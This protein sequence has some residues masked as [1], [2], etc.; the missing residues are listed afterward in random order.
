MTAIS[1]HLNYLSSFN[2]LYLYTNKYNPNLHELYVKSI[3]EKNKKKMFEKH[4]Y[5][6][7]WYT[8]P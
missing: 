5:T 2:L 3:Y 7:T 1:N 4:W 8:R 6:N